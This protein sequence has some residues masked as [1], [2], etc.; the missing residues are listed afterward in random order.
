MPDSQ[1]ITTLH[2][3]IETRE[4]DTFVTQSLASRDATTTLGRVSTEDEARIL[5]R[6]GPHPSSI[7]AVDVLEHVVDEEAWL[8]AIRDALPDGGSLVIRVPFEGPV[9][10][11]D[12]RN[13]YRYLQDVTGWGKRLLETQ[14]KGWHRHYT[15]R[16]L[17]RLLGD[18]G[19]AI[20]RVEQHG[21]P[22]HDVAQLGRL[23]W[24]KLIR[25]NEMAEFAAIERRI[26]ADAGLALPRLGP[27]STKIAAWATKR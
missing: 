23:V 21:S 19:F 12:A 11:L 3:R 10:W 4:R 8:Q 5:V 18:A 9:A 1:H 16:D 27:F 13:V 7:R 17:E 26:D 14:T 15:R 22:A 6:D 20:D 2:L 24:G 25:G